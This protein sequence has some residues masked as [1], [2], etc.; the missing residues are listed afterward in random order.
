M[1][2]SLFGQGRACWLDGHTS[3][4]T[5]AGKSYRGRKCCTKADEVFERMEADLHNLERSTDVVFVFP[6][7]DG[8]KGT[9]SRR[10]P[11]GFGEAAIVS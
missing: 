11:H 10:Q 4:R 1:P 6:R 8:R 2:A 9:L 5:S 7:S 3:C